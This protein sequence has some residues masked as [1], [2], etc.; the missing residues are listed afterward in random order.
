M[1]Q[2]ISFGNVAVK[3]NLIILLPKQLVCMSLYHLQKTGEKSYLCVFQWSCFIFW[4]YVQGNGTGFMLRMSR[5][6][7]MQPPCTTT[8]ICH[9]TSSTCPL[10][11]VLV[12]FSC[13]LVAWVLIKCLGTQLMCDI[14]ACSL[15]I[16]C[17]KLTNKWLVG[18]VSSFNPVASYQ[19]IT[20]CTSVLHFR[21]DS[22][23]QCNL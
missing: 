3:S 15:F 6:N 9:L 16:Y 11:W 12:E 18:A 14:L 4:W 19:I 20:N 10:T 8:L 2:L 13:I 22:Q 1:T 7:D 5:V 21:Q 23:I 17:I